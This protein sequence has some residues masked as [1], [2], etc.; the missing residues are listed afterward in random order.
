MSSDYMPRGQR[1]ALAWMR[2]FAVGIAAN[3][4]RYQCAPTDGIALQQA[5][6]EY[7]QALRLAESD[8]TR[9]KSTVSLKDQT[10]NTA[11]QICRVYYANIKANAGVS[12][13][14]KLEIGVRPLNTGRS[15]IQCPTTAPILSIIGATPLCHTLHY[16]DSMT[17]DSPGKPFGALH[18]RLF[19]AINDDRTITKPSE[20]QFYG[21]FTRNPVGVA[22]TSEDD[23]RVAT[24]FA[25]WAGRRNDVGPWSVPISFRIAG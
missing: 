23:G 20:A 18:L 16:N 7:Q 22:F 1:Q 5:V 19:V 10:R 21:T 11:E 25:R 13:Q 8:K 12:D 9:T 15:R 6:D 14:A 24:Y 3:P 4:G 17:P 2:T